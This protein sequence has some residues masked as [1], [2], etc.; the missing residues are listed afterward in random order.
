[1]AITRRILF[2]TRQASISSQSV[3]AMQTAATTQRIQPAPAKLVPE[4]VDPL[5]Q[6]LSEPFTT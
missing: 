3:K 4:A 2:R 1:M 5:G 6:N